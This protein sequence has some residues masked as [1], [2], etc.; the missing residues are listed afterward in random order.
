MI[1]E[2]DDPSASVE[3][4]RLLEDGSHRI[5]LRTEFETVQEA[6]GKGDDGQIEV[7]I[8]RGTNAAPTSST[9]NLPPCVSY[10]NP[11]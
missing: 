9:T 1:K 6:T 11:R 10:P 8:K 2:R 7:R 5:P 4:Y 3:M